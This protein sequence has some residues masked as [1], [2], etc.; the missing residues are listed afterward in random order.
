[1][2]G[3]NTSQ[4]D[5]DFQVRTAKEAGFATVTLSNWFENQKTQF[6]AQ[7]DWDKHPNAEGNK[8]IAQKLYEALREEQKTIPHS[9]PASGRTTVSN[10]AVTPNTR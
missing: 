10:T 7:A 8:L 2:V 4:D 1:M 5:I 6:L 3:E 9:L